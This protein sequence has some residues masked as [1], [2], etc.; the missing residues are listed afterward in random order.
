MVGFNAAPQNM[1][2]YKKEG[3]LHATDCKGYDS[4]F[5]LP[6]NIEIDESEFHYDGTEV[7]N[8][9]TAQSQLARSYAKHNVKNRQNR[10]I[11]T[12]F[13]EMVA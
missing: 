3:F 10:I 5:L 13:A 8:N 4:Y 12:K 1:K 6:D 2:K 11:L 9:R 7:A